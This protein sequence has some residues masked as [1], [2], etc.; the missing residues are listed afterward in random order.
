MLKTSDPEF[1]SL[2]HDVVSRGS[3]LRGKA[4]GRSMYP[5]VYSGDCLVIEHRDIKDLR[6]GDIVFFRNNYGTYITH[7]MVRK[8]GSSTIITRGDNTRHFDP[9]ITAERVIGKV[10][11]IESHGKRLELTGRTSCFYGYMIARFAG[12]RFRGQIRVMR[13]LNRAWWLAGG[14]RMK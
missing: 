8:N 14:R 1:A 4:I 3:H 11:K 12:I 9:P 5:L 2:L 13:L 7:R 10:I 6:V